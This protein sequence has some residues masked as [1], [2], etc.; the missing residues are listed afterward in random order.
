MKPD[1]L[2][3]VI[4]HDGPSTLTPAILHFNISAK[5]DVEI[6]TSSFQALIIIAVNM[7]STEYI[8]S[9]SWTTHMEEINFGACK[10]NY[11]TNHKQCFVYSSQNGLEHMAINNNDNALAINSYTFTG[12]DTYT[13]AIDS[14][15][16]YGGFWVY[17]SSHKEFNKPVLLLEQCG[18]LKGLLGTIFSPLKYMAVVVVQYSGI[19]SSRLEY[20]FLRSPKTTPPNLLLSPVNRHQPIIV[21][22]AFNVL[23]I[24]TE[25]KNM[26][27]FSIE[28][29]L[30]SMQIGYLPF[31]IY[32]IHNTLAP[33]CS[34]KAT[35]W[36]IPR[37]NERSWCTHVHHEH[38]ALQ[39]NIYSQ[40]WED[41]HGSTSVTKILNVT[42]NCKKC[43]ITGITLLQ[44]EQVR[45]DV[46]EEHRRN[47]NLLH[48]R[49]EFF[50][51]SYPFTLH[52][53][54]NVK[55]W[56]HVNTTS[57]F[58]MKIFSPARRNPSSLSSTIIFSECVNVRKIHIKQTLH[59]G[60]HFRHLS[61]GCINNCFVTITA[62]GDETG[63]KY[64][65]PS[66]KLK[67]K[68][69]PMH[70]VDYNHRLYRIIGENGDLNW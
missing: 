2:Q 23:H 53:Y 16:Q 68:I 15:C 66:L 24:L 25:I 67:I 11:F 37:V 60:Q 17:V 52:R 22:S 41:F 4:I 51:R 44:L 69:S 31:K 26:N 21:K 34:C 70:A 43:S 58:E 39:Q 46:F 9:V 54:R 38:N 1:I 47:L 65:D 45:N 33:D 30:Q 8:L 35:I 28:F 27:N 19:S 18:P 49:P 63:M 61:Q 13:N 64:S 57:E 36:H 12:P 14:M 42:F 50:R 56:L 59:P 6:M 5:E 7:I 29:S 10:Q 55:I 62:N 48:I 32:F 20:S 3:E 40:L